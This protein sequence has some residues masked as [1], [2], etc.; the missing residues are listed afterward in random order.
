MP[1]ENSSGHITVE[2][3]LHDYTWSCRNIYSRRQRAAID[4]RYNKMP[5]TYLAHYSVKQ[6]TTVKK[7]FSLLYECCLQIPPHLSPKRRGKTDPYNF[8]EKMIKANQHSVYSLHKLFTQQHAEMTTNCIKI[9]RR[10]FHFSSSPLH[11]SK[12]P[13]CFSQVP[14]SNEICSI[15]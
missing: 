13:R 4:K 9:H 3:P 12:R 1:H 10:K 14:H 8:N 2:H 6:Y 7:S 5:N 15:I 11:N